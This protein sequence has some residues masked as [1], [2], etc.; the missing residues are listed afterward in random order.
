MPARSSCIPKPASKKLEANAPDG[1]LTVP[2]IVTRDPE[3]QGARGGD[4]D[5]IVRPRLG[6][7]GRRREDQADNHE[8]AKHRVS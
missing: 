1:V 6:R 5:R 2:S 4:R 7:P 8:C 3:R